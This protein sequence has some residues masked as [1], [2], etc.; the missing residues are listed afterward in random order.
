M[1]DSIKRN[2]FFLLAWVALTVV[3]FISLGWAWGVTTLVIIPAYAALGWQL[4]KMP[5]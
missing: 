5:R 1:I 3:N 4:G 2:L